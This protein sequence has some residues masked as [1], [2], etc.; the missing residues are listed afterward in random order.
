M[1]NRSER[2]HNYKCPLFCMHKLNWILWCNTVVRMKIMESLSPLV[3]FMS[4]TESVWICSCVHHDFLIRTVRGTNCFVIW[5]WRSK[6]GSIKTLSLTS[7]HTHIHT[8]QLRFFKMRLLRSIAKGIPDI[9]I[10]DGANSQ[11]HRT[12][13]CTVGTHL[14]T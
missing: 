9:C 3:L 8:L 10:L 11:R 5:E 2:F 14:N 1:L 12:A 7:V 13:V 4:I 6:G